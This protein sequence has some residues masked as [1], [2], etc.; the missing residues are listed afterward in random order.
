MKIIFGILW[1]FFMVLFYLAWWN[2][3]TLTL[4][5]IA[6][7]YWYFFAIWFLAR[8]AYEFSE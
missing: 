3:D 8:F 6:K 2:H 1:L 7:E 5:Q 4:M